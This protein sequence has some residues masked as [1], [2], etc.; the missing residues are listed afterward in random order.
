MIEKIKRLYIDNYIDFN[1]VPADCK[2][3]VFTYLEKELSSEEQE[4][5]YQYMRYKDV[6][7]ETNCFCYVLSVY[8]YHMLSKLPIEDLI[9]DKDLNNCIKGN[10]KILKI[11]I[12]DF[13]RMEI[14]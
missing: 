14:E 8:I 11:C 3:C 5:I 10:E 1:K 7:T 4:S 2:N 9:N 12:K 6:D 13:N